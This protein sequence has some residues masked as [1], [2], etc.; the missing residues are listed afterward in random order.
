M[1]HSW[2][3]RCTIEAK[4]RD[5]PC[6]Y[7]CRILK[8]MLEGHY[9]Y[10]SSIPERFASMSEI[11]YQLKNSTGGP[12]LC[13][14]VEFVQNLFCTEMLARASVPEVVTITCITGS[15]RVRNE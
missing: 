8:W 5:S 10:W 3:C 6:I 7:A 15:Q 11:L 14:D 12:R 1:S 4:S 2:Y 13:M 9:A